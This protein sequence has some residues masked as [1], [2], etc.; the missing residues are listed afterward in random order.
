MQEKAQMRIPILDLSVQYQQI[1][2]EIQAAVER[3]LNSQQ[4]IL[5]P[6]V[7]ELEREI[8]PYCQCAE[9]VGCA[10]G[11]DALL[12]AL[13]ACGIG[14]GDEV[15]TTPCSFFATVGSIVR[16]GARDVFVDI[17]EA[18]FNINPSLVGEKI[19]SRTKAIVP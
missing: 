11:S 1:A 15:I 2:G 5:G 13:M 3:V 16:L 18:T 10:S 9:A 4:F 6:E 7:R 14:P 8:A 12:L 19:T 17:D